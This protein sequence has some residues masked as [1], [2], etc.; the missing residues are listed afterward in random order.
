VQSPDINNFFWNQMN[1]TGPSDIAQ[2]VG[3]NPNRGPASFIPS[4]GTQPWTIGYQAGRTLPD[5]AVRHQMLRPL[6]GAINNLGTNNAGAALAGAGIGG[7]IGAGSALVGGGNVGRRTAVGAGVGSLGMLL[8]SLYARNRLN[9]TQYRQIEP[10]ALPGRVKSSF[11]AV[12]EGSQEIG[13]KLLSDSGLSSADKTMLL[14]YVQRLPNS[15]KAELA[16]LIGPAVGAG[17]GIIIARYLMRLGIGGT[18]IMALLGAGVGRQIT[19]GPR[20]AYGH[21]INTRRD[22]FGQPRFV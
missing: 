20:D 5:M 21:V 18:A 1:R 2:R 22:A 12:G 3:I 15:Q 7:A 10:P 16:H 19:S 4:P 6:R 17:I 13:S 8:L 11:Y 9:N 14:N